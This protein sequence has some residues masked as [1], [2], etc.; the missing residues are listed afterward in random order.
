[1]F[2]EG[3]GLYCMLCKK[4]DMKNPRNK[5]TVFSQESSKRFRKGTLTDHLKCKNHQDAKSSEVLNRVSAF[6]KALDHKE[7][8]NQDI[9]FQA[10]YSFF[11]LAK[12]SIANCKIVQLLK[13]IEHIG[14]ND[15]T[16][17]THRFVQSRPDILLKISDTIQKNLLEKLHKATS[18]GLLID[19]MSDVATMEQMVCYVQYFDSDLN[20]VKTDFLFICNILE[21]ADSANSKTLFNVL[22]MKL[23]E[24]KM[25][26]KKV[27]GLCTD[28][29]SVMLGKKDVL[30]TKLKRENSSLIAVHCICH[31]LAL[32]CTDANTELKSI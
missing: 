28:G 9:L 24:L 10:F 2:I 12:E 20:E 29:A 7:S 15:I 1:M 21:N 16:Y 26:V 25:D 6:Q 11:F 14:L 22:C 30:A 27:S 5:S 19:D 13:F 4:H 23:K 17:S 31:R 32:A 8:V 18:Y 3:D